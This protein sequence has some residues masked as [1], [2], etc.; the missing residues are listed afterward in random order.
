MKYIELFYF[1]LFYSIGYN[2]HAAEVKPDT[3]DGNSHPRARLQLGHEGLA[4]D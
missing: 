2:R 3:E 4:N 1:K